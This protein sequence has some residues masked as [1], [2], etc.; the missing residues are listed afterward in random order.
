MSQPATFS[1]DAVRATQR[2]YRHE[3]GEEPATWL[4][5]EYL[6]QSAEAICQRDGWTGDYAAACQ[7]AEREALDYASATRTT[8]LVREARREVSRAVAGI[9]NYFEAL[10]CL[11]TLA[12]WLEEGPDNNTAEAWREHDTLSADLARSVC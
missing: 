1:P 11:Q 3:T 7:V 8:L 4:A 10:A 9:G 12:H 6:H 5:I 2:M